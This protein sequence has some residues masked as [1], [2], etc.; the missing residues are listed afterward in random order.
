MRQQPRHWF[1]LELQSIFV[2]EESCHGMPALQSVS[3]YK[4]F[5]TFLGNS[6]Y[7]VLEEETKTSAIQRCHHI[8]LYNKASKTY[9]D[10][11]GFFKWLQ[12][13]SFQMTMLLTL[14][15]SAFCVRISTF[16]VT[17]SYIQ[18]ST[19]GHGKFY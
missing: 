6:S 14:L 15:Q 8:R 3:F 7:S 11:P 12:K 4:I 1:A 19:A 2:E 16:D 13:K 9:I 17:A 18:A 5:S 10:F